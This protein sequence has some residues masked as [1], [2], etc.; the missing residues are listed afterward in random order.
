MTGFSDTNF[1]REYI[2]RDKLEDNFQTGKQKLLPFTLNP[3]SGSVYDGTCGLNGVTGEFYRIKTQSNVKPIYSPQDSEETLR[4][5][6]GSRFNMPADDIERFIKV[7]NDVMFEND[8]LNVIDPSFFSF[9]PM[10][11]FDKV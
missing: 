11:Y 5:E 9:V 1:L 6:L 10:K 7:F 4:K 3:I 2:K 8:T